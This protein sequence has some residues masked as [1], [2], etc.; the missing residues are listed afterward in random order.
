MMGVN[1]FLLP[2]RLSD[3][4]SLGRYVLPFLRMLCHMGFA[5][6]HSYWAL[7]RLVA[8][9]VLRFDRILHAW[10]STAPRHTGRVASLSSS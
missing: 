7:S 2:N 4:T 3:L 9:P 6:I 1:W 10:R 5:A 8:D